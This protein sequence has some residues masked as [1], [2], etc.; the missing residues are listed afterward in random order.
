MIVKSATWV[1]APFGAE[2]ACF[3]F[4]HKSMSASFRLLKIANKNNIRCWSHVKRM[5]LTASK[6]KA[7][8]IQPLGKRPRGRAQNRWEDDIP[9]WYNEMGIPM[10]QVN[11]W[12]K[13]RR[14][15]VYPLNVDGRRV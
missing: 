8:V 14:P 10:T 12:V 5:A 11:N 7:L 13:D 4:A 3:G 1:T 9:K 2:C 15:I 6:S